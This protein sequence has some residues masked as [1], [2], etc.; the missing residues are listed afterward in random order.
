MGFAYLVDH[1][2]YEEVIG[3]F[4]PDGVFERPGLTADGPQAIRE[5]LLSRPEGVKTRHVCAPPFFDH[6]DAGCARSI[7]YVTIFHGPGADDEAISV[8]GPAG[9]VEFHDS[10]RLTPD[11]WRIAHHES[12]IAILATH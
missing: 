1:R 10:F 5:F 11:G 4:A 12:R 9:V 7:T 6:V 8:A 3:L 2:R